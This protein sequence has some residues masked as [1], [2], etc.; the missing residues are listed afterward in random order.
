MGEVKLPNITE[1]KLL[2]KIE[3][4]RKVA[5]EAGARLLEARPVDARA[6]SA[7][8]LLELI[9]QMSKENRKH[10]VYLTAYEKNAIRAWYRLSLLARAKNVEKPDNTLG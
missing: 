5:R 7:L 9:Y 10:G 8:A 3:H 6:K 2:A 1:A 4:I